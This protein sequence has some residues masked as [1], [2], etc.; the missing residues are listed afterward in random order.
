MATRAANIAESADGIS[1]GNARQILE[2]GLLN[3]RTLASAASDDRLG[4]ARATVY[5]VVSVYWRELQ[6][7][8]GRRWSLCKLPADIDIAAIPEKARELAETLGTA[9]AK[10]DVMDAGYMIG[11]LY[12]GMMPEQFR[13]ALGA[14]Y[15]P[16]P[17]CERLLDMATEAGVNWR[18]ARVLDPACGGGAFLSP[19]A[20]RMA[21]GLEDCSATVTLK[22]IQR[23]LHGFEFDPFAAWMSQVFLDVTL[24]DLCHAAETRLRSVVHVCDSLAQTPEDDGFDLVIGNPPYGRPV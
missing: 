23:R 4:F 12:T 14:Y 6:T 24:S 15:T 21:K 20:R 17:L 8:S 10:L 2:D 22:D 11:V 3:A 16:P 5:S 18:T 13:A 1:T 7:A 9:A 19:V